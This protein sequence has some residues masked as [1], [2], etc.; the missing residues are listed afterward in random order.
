MHNT[1]EETIEKFSRYKSWDLTEP[2]S[3]QMA[4]AKEVMTISIRIFSLR[5]PKQAAMKE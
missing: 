5:I 3:I 1:F 4:G 2:M